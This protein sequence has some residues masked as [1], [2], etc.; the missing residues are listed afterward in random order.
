MVVGEWRKFLGDKVEV[1]AVMVVAV[2][3]VF[4]SGGKGGG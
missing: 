4:G 3:E 2:R 1:E